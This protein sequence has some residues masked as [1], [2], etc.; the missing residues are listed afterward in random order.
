MILVGC[1]GLLIFCSRV[2]N[3]PDINI[4]ANVNT[5]TQ[6]ERTTCVIGTVALAV[7]IPGCLCYLSMCIDRSRIYKHGKPIT[8]STT[9]IINPSKPIN[10][11]YDGNYVA[12]QKYKKRRRK[13]LS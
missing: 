12:N 4:F 3:S 11:H 10:P 8:T 13:T 1:V 5:Q 9:N 6:E 7:L 2:S